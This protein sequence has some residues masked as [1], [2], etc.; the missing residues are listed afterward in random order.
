[1][2]LPSSEIIHHFRYQCVI[3]N[4]MNS[5]SIFNIFFCDCSFHSFRKLFMIGRMVPSVESKFAGQNDSMFPKRKRDSRYVCHRIF[6]NFAFS[7]NSSFESVYQHFDFNKI[8]KW[9]GCWCHVVALSINESRRNEKKNICV[10]TKSWAATVRNECGHCYR[11][12]YCVHEKPIYVYQSA[13]RG[14]ATTHG[15]KTRQ[16]KE[17]FV[18]GNAMKNERISEVNFSTV[19]FVSVWHQPDFV[20]S[21]TGNWRNSKLNKNKKH[22]HTHPYCYTYWF[23]DNSNENSE[24]RSSDQQLDVCYVTIW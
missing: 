4:R 14:R 13:I 15:Y 10:R 9:V 24:R 3:E 5:A 20:W 19:E 17:E 18:C 7:A 12:T 11:N 6:Y 23:L 2:R 16:K 22:T 8:F 21:L 1:M